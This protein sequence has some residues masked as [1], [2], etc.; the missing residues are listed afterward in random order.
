MNV[1]PEMVAAPMIEI[2]RPC[3]TCGEPI[4]WHILIGLDQPVDTSDWH[5]ITE[6]RLR[7]SDIFPHVLGMIPR[8]SSVDT[9]APSV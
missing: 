3:F 1:L 2:M 5:N 6:G 7:P 9:A 4:A 8:Q